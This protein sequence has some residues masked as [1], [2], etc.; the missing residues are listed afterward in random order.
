MIGR[1]NGLARTADRIPSYWSILVVSF[2]VTKLPIKATLVFLTSATAQNKEFHGD[3]NGRCWRFWAV[4]AIGPLRSWPSSQSASK[5]LHSLRWNF[6]PSGKLDVLKLPRPSAFVLGDHV[7]QS[8]C[9]RPCVVGS[10]KNIVAVDK[11]VSRPTF[12]ERPHIVIRNLSSK[13]FT[14]FE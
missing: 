2:L 10:C 12:R 14:D 11:L 8:S 1:S 9:R 4:A 3:R 6:I 5:S 7:E 13:R